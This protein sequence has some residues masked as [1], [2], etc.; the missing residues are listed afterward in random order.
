MA[1]LAQAQIQR[2][3]A[4]V[5]WMS[6]RDS[7]D[8]VP[9]PVVARELGTSVAALKAD[10]QVLLRLTESYKEWLG[11]LSVL[12]TATGIIV[13]SRGAFRRPLRLSRDE[14][15]A[16]MVGLTGVAGGRELAGR[17]G[18]GFDSAPDPAEAADQYAL[19]PEPGA[20]V[21]ATLALARQARDA[22]CKLR[23]TYCGSAGEPSQRVIQ[24]HQVVQAAGVWYVVA[25]CERAASVRH[26]RSER[27]L[28][29]EWLDQPFEPRNDLPML[30]S[31]GE[32]L[33]AD[34]AETAL[35]A[36]SPA[37]A[38][39][40]R[41]KHPGGETGA[42]GRYRVQ[43]PVADPR[44]LA[45]EVLQYGAE[46]EVLEPPAMREVIRDLIGQG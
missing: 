42:D 19:G 33:A 32:L 5:A 38:R 43:L 9:Y 44:W 14:A 28:E 45:R 11:S 35:V 25:W 4:L 16:L 2:I 13:S 39:W 46:A 8:P 27:I 29:T 23:I 30:S 6:Q 36:F 18:G 12:I 31:M 1:D 17:L 22:H 15:L 24:V 20:G 21:A 26:F 7:G 34:H 41:E 10:L 3:V 37:I 40:I